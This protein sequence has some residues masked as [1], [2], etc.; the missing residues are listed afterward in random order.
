MGVGFCQFAWSGGRQSL[1]VDRHDQGAIWATHRYHGA[2]QEDWPGLSLCRVI[3]AVS[4]RATDARL[5]PVWAACCVTVNHQTKKMKR[6]TFQNQFD[7]PV[8]PLLPFAPF[9]PASLGQGLS[10][11][12][13][14]R[15][16]PLNKTP[17]RYVCCIC[18]WCT[19]RVKNSCFVSAFR[20]ALFSSRNYDHHKSMHVSSENRTGLAP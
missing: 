2:Q 10:P 7:R 1:D 16:M 9:V 3:A 18:C 4:W 15:C 20:R 17:L 5:L 8:D 11:P 14:G 12:V 6:G 13:N 19:W